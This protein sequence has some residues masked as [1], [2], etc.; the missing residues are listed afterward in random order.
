MPP[1]KASRRGRKKAPAP[2]EV[3]A[4]AG[5]HDTDSCHGESSSLHGSTPGLLAG[6]SYTVREGNKKRLM[7]M[8]R[9]RNANAVAR[10]RQ[11]LEA[12]AAKHVSR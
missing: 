8:N 1:K 5:D 9:E 10:K 3:E 11:A 7:R 2:K 4:S 12:E 6:E